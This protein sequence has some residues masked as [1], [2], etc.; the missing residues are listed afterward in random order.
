MPAV[1]H[2]VLSRLRERG[3]RAVGSS[4]PDGA[5]SAFDARDYQLIV[6]GSGVVGPVSQRLRREFGLR[7]PSVRFLDAFGPIAA[8]QVAAALS[9]RGALIDDVRVVDEE[10]GWRVRAT[11]LASCTVR[12]DLYHLTESEELIV[13]ALAELP[14]TT[15]PVEWRGESEHGAKGRMLVVS[16]GREGEDPEFHTH[17]LTQAAAS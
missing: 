13:E 9:D 4:E 7:N 8:G 15:G 2:N 1:L 16:A 5:A 3:V 10:S 14:V 11:A 6:F 17:R 12:I